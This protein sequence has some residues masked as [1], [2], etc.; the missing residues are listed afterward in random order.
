MMRN[1]AVRR[2][3]NYH[4]GQSQLS[5]GFG[6]V[7]TR[8]RLPGEQLTDAGVVKAKLDNGATVVT[9]DK[10]GAISTVGFIVD[11]GTKY[12]PA[13]APGL[14]N[15][16]QYALLTSNMSNSTFQLDRAFRA[17]GASY[18]SV[19]LNK[20]YV[21][22]LA[23]S[24][25]P[26]WGVGVDQIAPCIAAPRFA[27]SDLERFRDFLDARR[28]ESRW[29]NPREYAVDELETVA[30]FKEP[31]GNPRS[32]P[33]AMNGKAN[34]VNLL[35]KF[36]SFITPERVTIVGINVPHQELVARYVG[37]EFKHS[38]TAPHHAATAA[39]AL[40]H[41]DE[42]KQYH[43]GAQRFEQEN[44]AAAMLTKPDMESE[45]IVA[46]G[47]LAPGAQASAA[48]YA[49]GLVV[50]EMLAIRAGDG[51]NTARHDP[52]HGVR[53]FY[54]PYSTAGLMG[55]TVRASPDALTADVQ[56]ALKSLPN[57]YV[58]D[59]PA[60]KARATSVLFGGNLDA[61]RDYAGFIATSSFSADELAR[62]I[63][64][65]AV[66]NVS[67]VIEVMKSQAPCVFGTGDVAGIPAVRRMLA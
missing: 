57:D 66:P 40:E 33:P 51:I 32:L 48:E 64:A 53:A 65:V 45:G 23:A 54:R 43:A 67:D 8:Q 62:A 49:A 56:K 59:L 29:Q 10:G 9:H 34:T 39:R 63:D 19:E 18:G 44:R 20:R 50:A 35:E 13:A 47:W 55:F 16:L 15:M 4:F 42:A 11:A 60:A 41:T 1:T 2:I 7:K 38:A 37:Q 31:L 61:S 26:F 27:E 5:S 17:V 52:H 30:F 21:G 58:S 36:A 46:L 12:D 28:E 24:A 14:T 3:T 25:R 6:Q 22:W